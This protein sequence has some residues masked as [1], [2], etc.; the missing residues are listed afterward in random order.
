MGILQFNTQGCLCVQ[1]KFLSAS[2]VAASP[3]QSV[4]PAVIYP[5]ATGRC[6]S[7]LDLPL[8]GE[9]DFMDVL[10]GVGDPVELT[11]LRTWSMPC[12]SF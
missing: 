6:R 8:A 9:R 11:H 10:S 5:W 2:E 3:F 7:R 12:L 4:Y 1:E